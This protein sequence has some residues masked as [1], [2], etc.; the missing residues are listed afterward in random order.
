MCRSSYIDP[1]IIDLY[2][3]GVTIRPA[4][5]RL[6]D[7]SDFGAPATHGHVEAA[8]LAM[9]AEP[10]RASG[11]QAGRAAKALP[12]RP[13]RLGSTSPATRRAS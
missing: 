11:N 7:D 6:G 9:L 4:L 8:V 10:S 2:D 1:R 13:A 3:D 12:R 5:E